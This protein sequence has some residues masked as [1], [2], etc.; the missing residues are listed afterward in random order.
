MNL[1]ENQKIV[2]TRSEQNCHIGN[3]F[4]KINKYLLGLLYESGVV[5]DIK[6]FVKENK[7]EHYSAIKQVYLFEA[8]A[9]YYLKNR[10]RYE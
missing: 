8:S 6:S 4:Y 9:I 1:S 5:R 7:L 10:Q 2:K 3:S